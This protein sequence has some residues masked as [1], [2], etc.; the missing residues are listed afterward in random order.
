VEAILE[1]RILNLLRLS[2]SPSDLNNRLYQ[3]VREGALML[4]QSPIEV[5]NAK[6]L[7]GLTVAAGQR[8]GKLRCN[9][10]DMSVQFLL[11][12]ALAAAQKVGSGHLLHKERGRRDAIR[13]KEGCYA[14]NILQA[15]R[16]YP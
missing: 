1:E 10:L 11:H 12:V 8:V 14:D 5:R 4:T 3:N 2:V 13:K 7:G 16:E 6:L 9:F 15:Y